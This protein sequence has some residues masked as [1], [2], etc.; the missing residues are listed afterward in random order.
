MLPRTRRLSTEEFQ[1]AFINGRKFAGKYI[2][3]THFPHGPS[4]VAV[5]VP[6]KIEKSSVLRHRMKRRVFGVLERFESI[7]QGSVILNCKTKQINE[8]SHKDLVQGII[9]DLS[10][11]LK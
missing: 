2:L 10:R 9:D 6:K 4:R 3:V 5:V 8:I 7:P 1:K 11:I